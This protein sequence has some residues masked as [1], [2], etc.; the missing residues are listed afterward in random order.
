MGKLIP[1]QGDLKELRPDDYEALKGQIL[2]LGFSEPINVWKHKGKYRILNGHQRALTVKK[3]IDEGFK[4][5]PLPVS[6][7]E[8]ADWNEAA[9]KILGLTSQFGHVDEDGLT[10]FLKDSDI[11]PEE[12]RQFRLLDINTE[13][14]IDSFEPDVPEENDEADVPENPE[15]SQVRTV[16]LFFDEVT[17]EKFSAMIEELKIKHGTNSLT[18]TVLMA[19]EAADARNNGIHGW[20]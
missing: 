14:F 1:S 8:A 16:Q 3:M 15:I 6:L 7:T 4:C 19:V 10:E 18:E 17:A 20:T 12:L 9:R 11:S 2:E 13:K 5:G